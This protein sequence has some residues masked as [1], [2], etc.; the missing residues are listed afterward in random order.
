MFLLKQ[1]T[2][3]KIVER[4]TGTVASVGCQSKS[5]FADTLETSIFVYTHAVKAH[6]GGG[7]FIVIWG[8]DQANHLNE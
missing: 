6:V 2:H 4:L 3:V 1:H 7:T 8:K 5:R